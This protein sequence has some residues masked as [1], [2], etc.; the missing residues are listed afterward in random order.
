MKKT[1]KS[2]ATP[3]KKS[4]SKKP[5]PKKP[6]AKK[7]A[8]FAR[9]F[10]VVLT[11]LHALPFEYDGG[12]GMDFE[13]YDEFM[14]PDENTSW[15]RAWTGNQELTGHEYRVFGQDGTGGYAAFWI[16]RPD[17]DLLEQPIVFFGSEGE[18]GVVA[19]DFNDYLWVLAHGAGPLEAIS[20]G[21]ETSK[22][23]DAFAKFAAK[24]APK[25]KKTAKQAIAAAKKQYPHFEKHIR[26]LVKH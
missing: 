17:A 24:H 14:A 16:V 2:K 22:P 13:P 3:K 11:E 20:Y 8:G 1:K 15:I 23:N 21:A 7:P 10:P 9:T 19:K 25:A 12:E 26:S 4:P 18:L 5:A 6:A